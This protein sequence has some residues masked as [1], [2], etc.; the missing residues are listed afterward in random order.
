MANAKSYLKEG[1]DDC[2]KMLSNWLS[3]SKKFKVPNH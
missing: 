1:Y 3:R 2:L